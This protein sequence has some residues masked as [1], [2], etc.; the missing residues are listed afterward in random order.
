MAK[1][2]QKGLNIPQLVSRLKPMG[3]IEVLLACDSVGTTIVPL[4]RIELDSAQDV[5]N[6]ADAVQVVVLYPLGPKPKLS[7]TEK[8]A[9]AFFNQQVTQAAARNGGKSS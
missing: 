3:R 8:E 4:G 9:V 7:P 5:D 2:R 6:P 1:R